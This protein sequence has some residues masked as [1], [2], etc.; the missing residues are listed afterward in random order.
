MQ[1]HRCSSISIPDAR[2]VA[3]RLLVVSPNLEMGA[4]RHRLLLAAG[5]NPDTVN[6]ATQALSLIRSNIYA[7]LILGQMLDY[8]NKSLLIQTAHA[9]HIP[10]IAIH[11]LPLEDSCKADYCVRITQGTPGL[12]DALR[13]AIL[14][15]RSKAKWNT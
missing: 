12:L 14:T 11:A 8:I 6:S 4:R 1:D 13:Q 2:P 7:A 15:P 5:Y 9:L 10:V 3:P